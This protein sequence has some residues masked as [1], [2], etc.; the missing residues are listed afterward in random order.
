MAASR[1]QFDHLMPIVLPAIFFLV[2]GIEAADWIM[3]SRC[4]DIIAH[5]TNG[6]YLWHI[7]I[8]LILLLLLDGAIGNR[9]IAAAGWFLMLYLITVVAVARV[10]YLGIEL[11]ARQTI[12]RLTE[13][14]GGRQ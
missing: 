3:T 6:V 1:I 12:R 9:S 11:P 10:S 2:C 5:N 7:P 14:P 4:T 8:Q 13:F